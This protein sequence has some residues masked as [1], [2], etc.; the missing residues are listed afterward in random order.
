MLLNFNRLTK[1]KME[2]DL[3]NPLTG[4]EEHH[5]DAVSALFASESDHMPSFLAF[6]STDVRFCLRRDSLSLISQTQS[7]YKF[8]RY[9]AYLAVN[10]IDRFLSEQVVTENRPWIVRILVIASLSLAAKMTNFNLSLS[11]IQRDVGVIFDAQ[12]IPRME[13]LILTTLEWRLRSITPFSFL[14][15]CMSLFQLG[16]SSLTQPLKRRASDIIFSTQY[17]TKL[18]EYKP[19]IIAASALLCAADELIPLRFSSFLAA[20]SECQYL[21]K[22]ELMNALAV[23]REMLIEGRE[24][25]V[26]KLTPKSV[27]ECECTTSECEKPTNLDGDSMKRRKLNDFRDETFRIS[28]IQRC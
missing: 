26:D 1:G 11:D 15:F 21:T 17:E 13:S 22:E 7:A 16:D 18:F 6:K 9:M 25:T 12:S 20:I 14:H 24:S 4:F 5:F 2:F 3:E 10:Y 8:D 27:L 19:S 23:I 28:H